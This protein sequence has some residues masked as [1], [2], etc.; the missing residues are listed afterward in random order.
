M[1]GAGVGPFVR[2]RPMMVIAMS[3]SYVMTDYVLTSI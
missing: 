3:D 1:T 2:D